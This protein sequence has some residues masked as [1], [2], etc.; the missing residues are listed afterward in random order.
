MAGINRPFSF[1]YINN[2]GYHSILIEENLIP[3]GKMRFVKDAN[4]LV[5]SD[6]KVKTTTALWSGLITAVNNKYETQFTQDMQSFITRVAIIV[7]DV[8]LEAKIGAH[9][10]LGAIDYLCLKVLKNKTLYNMLRACAVNDEGNTIKHNKY[11]I[12][13]DIPECINQ[14]N[15]LIK[16][17]VGTG[18]S[19]F[20]NYYLRAEAVRYRD[21]PV[22]VE[23]FDLKYG[24][25]AGIRHSVQLD[26][27]SIKMDQYTKTVSADVVVE[28]KDNPDRYCSFEVLINN[29]KGD[30]EEESELVKI[31]ESMKIS[32]LNYDSMTLNISVPSDRLNRRKLQVY[33]NVKIFE[34]YQTGHLLWK[35][36]AYHEL[37]NNCSVVSVIV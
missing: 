32:M 15:K 19:V 10:Y 29:G 24:M 30:D 36:D 5:E 14:F 25:V 20:N 27:N 13:I 22:F 33:V 9:T 2:G 1:P 18:L 4:R 3:E 26:K 28:W 17:L 23:K 16:G 6:L 7:S 8:S 34:K 11:N 37:G 12:D 35:K 21:K 31:G